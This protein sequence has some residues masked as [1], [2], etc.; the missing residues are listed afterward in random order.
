MEGQLQGWYRDPYGRY[1]LRYFSEGRPTNL[2]RTG[3]VESV[4]AVPPGDP[5]SAE[6]Q[7]ASPPPY[8]PGAF[9]SDPPP[10]RR[11][12]AALLWGLV[13]T[14]VVAAIAIGVVLVTNG[15][16]SS[17]PDAGQTL[18]PSVAD[19]G[20]VGELF[21]ASSGQ[22]KVRFETTPNEQTVPATIAGVKF[23][24]DVAGTRDP[25][26]LVESASFSQ[27]LPP[28][29]D[30]EMLRGALTTLPTTAGGTAGAQHETTFRGR[31]ARTETFTVPGLGKYDVLGFIYSARRMYLL[32]AG[33]GVPMTELENSFVAL[34]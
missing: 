23:S 28:G 12:R 2:V 11:R 6:A 29:E 33:T 26:A 27:S 14:A 10:R 16:G 21:T 18:T 13:A 9:V 5:L 19:T 8:P 4:D 7:Y 1:E 22:F 31:P 30:Q 24:M 34:P 17:H 25:L 15:G 3:G 20:T 32:V